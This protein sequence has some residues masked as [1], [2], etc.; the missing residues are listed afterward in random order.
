[1][2][3]RLLE[4][5]LGGGRPLLAPPP[6]QPVPIRFRFTKVFIKEPLSPFSQVHRAS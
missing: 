5:K 2:V 3:N 1:V 6:F 4:Q